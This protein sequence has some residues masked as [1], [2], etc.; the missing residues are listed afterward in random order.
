MQREDGRIRKLGDGLVH[1]L[2]SFSF[3]KWVKF[4]LNFETES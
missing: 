3:F 4:L 1:F 2:F